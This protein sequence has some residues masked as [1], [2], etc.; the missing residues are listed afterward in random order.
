MCFGNK[1]H[2]ANKILM[3]PSLRKMSC[4]SNYAR[5]WIYRLPENIFKMLNI[6]KCIMADIIRLLWTIN[7]S[8]KP[9][10][11]LTT[12]MPNYSTVKGIDDWI[13]RLTS[14]KPQH[15]TICQPEKVKKI[16]FTDDFT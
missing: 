11:L 12:K 8:G 16:Q 6:F 13:L 1:F 3:H 4:I 7:S 2:F 5:H 15:K 14:V 9:T 10:P